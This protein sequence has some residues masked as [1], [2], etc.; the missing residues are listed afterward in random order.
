MLNSFK[1]DVI[2]DE[3]QNC[4]FFTKLYQQSFKPHT[5]LLKMSQTL[6]FDEVNGSAEEKYNM[7][8]NLAQG[9]IKIQ[10]FEKEKIFADF[11]WSSKKQK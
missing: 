8:E 1:R 5:F 9:I 7:T 2:H 4:W 11:S 3:L 6:L 10:V